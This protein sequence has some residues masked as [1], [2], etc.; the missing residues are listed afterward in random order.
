M[1]QQETGKKTLLVFKPHSTVDVITNSSSELFVGIH[2]SKE[3]LEQLIEAIYPNY[4]NEYYELKSI[5]DLDDGE[6]NNYFGFA[7]SP[8]CY[9]A[10]KEMFPVLPGFTFDELYVRDKEKE[11]KKWNK[12]EHY[13]LKNNDP[14]SRWGI[15]VTED[16]FEEIKNKLDPNREMFFLFSI[17]D[18]P[19]FEMQEE[20]ERF[21]IRYH[22][23]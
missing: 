15:F 17:N 11:D 18:N 5:D 21:M 8:H 1:K 10:T 16:N 4:L 22:L 20:L 9:P 23:G 19:N 14:N 6:L 12:G 7:C 13:K 3:E 2:T